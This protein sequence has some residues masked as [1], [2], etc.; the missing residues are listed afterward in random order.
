L[1]AT[2][3]DFGL[4]TP[5]HALLVEKE[6]ANFLVKRANRVFLPIAFAAFGSMPIFAGAR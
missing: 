3:V 5:Q 2:Q 6:M 1:R 4:W